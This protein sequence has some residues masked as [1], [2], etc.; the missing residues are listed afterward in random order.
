M[1]LYFIIT[2]RIMSSDRIKESEDGVQQKS[3]DF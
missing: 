1:F 2:I 3:I